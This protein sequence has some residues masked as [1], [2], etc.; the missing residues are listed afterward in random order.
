M[1]VWRYCPRHGMVDSRPCKLCRREKDRKRDRYRNDPRQRIYQG[2]G[3]IGKKWR[4]ASREYREVARLCEG[5]DGEECGNL[6]EH[7]HHKVYVE[8]DDPRFLDPSYFQASCRSCH[9]RIEAK[10]M[11]RDEQGLWTG[12]QR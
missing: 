12:K 10:L 5:V 2:V 4:K 3:P 7:V 6:A 8:P 1:A 9:A 11:T